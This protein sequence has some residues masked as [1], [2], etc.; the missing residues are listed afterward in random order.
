[1]RELYCSAPLT[2]AVSRKFSI[3]ISSLG[4]TLGLS[5]RRLDLDKA[6][7][8]YIGY[9][10]EL[11]MRLIKMMTLPLVIASLITGSA[12]LNAKMSGMIALRTITYFLLTSLLAAIVG[13]AWVL[14]I[15]P[16]DSSIKSD[17]DIDGTTDREK[18]S[19]VDTFLDLGRNLVPDN[20]FQATFQSVSSISLA[21]QVIW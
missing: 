8:S 20:L 11:F 13:L 2:L 18:T 4:I 1:M 9:P 19:I 5:L 16:G 21:L 7:I 3:H 10:G 15:H 6:T 17:L 14:I 12:S